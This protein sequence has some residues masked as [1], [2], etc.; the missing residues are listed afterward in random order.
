MSS[1]RQQT[2]NKQGGASRGGA[3]RG[4]ASRGRGGASRGRGG[5]SRGRGGYGGRGRGGRFKKPKKIPPKKIDWATYIAPG[6]LKW[7]EIRSGEKK[8][9]INEK[10]IRLRRSEM[11]FLIDKSYEEFLPHTIPLRNNNVQKI[12]DDAE[13]FG[14]E[15]DNESKKFYNNQ[16]NNTPFNAFRI[17][18]NDLIPIDTNGADIHG[19]SF[20]QEISN[21]GSV[22]RFKQNNWVSFWDTRRGK[23]YENYIK[24]RKYRDERKKMHSG[25]IKRHDYE[26]IKT[27]SA[28]KE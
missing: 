14:W 15:Y 11:G 16:Y 20:V 21:D 7:Y 10:S 25:N 5:A 23:R 8:E 13:S 1:Q 9:H 4:G 27:S 26:S 24:Y 12:L 18:E 17:N 19:I 2:T 6:S 22:K 3:S 28:W